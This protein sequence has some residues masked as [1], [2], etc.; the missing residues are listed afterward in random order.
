MS[1]TAVVS[2]AAAF[3]LPCN[4]CVSLITSGWTKI[5]IQE[6]STSETKHGIKEATDATT[7]A[8]SVAM[9]T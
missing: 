9:N 4:R 8:L 1:T 6:A 2:K 5:A 3:A 7:N